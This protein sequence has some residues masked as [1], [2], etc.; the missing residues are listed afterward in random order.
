MFHA[1]SG[2]LVI[3][4]AVMMIIDV[5][6]TDNY[7]DFVLFEDCVGR[8]ETESTERCLRLLNS[9]DFYNLVTEKFTEEKKNL[10]VYDTT[11]HKE[12]C[13][14]SCRKYIDQHIQTDQRNE[15]GFPLKL[16]AGV[17]LCDFILFDYMSLSRR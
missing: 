12:Y 11:K 4:G 3:S 6:K 7:I 8:S 15:I 9:A 5:F 13:R 17:R 10:F 1:V 16:A 2:S 14:T